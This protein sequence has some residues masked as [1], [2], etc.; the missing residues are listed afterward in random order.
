[1][2]LKSFKPTSPGRRFYSVSDFNEITTREPERSP[3]EVEHAALHDEP[4]AMVRTAR[5]ASDRRWRR[6]LGGDLQH[7]DVFS[8][9]GGIADLVDVGYSRHSEALRDLLKDLKS[10][11]VTYPCK[12][13]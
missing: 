11:V 6:A 8:S 12:A 9:H 1:M 5:C 2:A 10:F 4:P 3:V 7:I 13:V